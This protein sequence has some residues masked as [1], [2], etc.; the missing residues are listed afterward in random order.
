[1][2]EGGFSQSRISDGVWGITCLL[3]IGSCTGKQEEVGLGEGPID[4]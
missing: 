2:S 1:M 3:R 4:L